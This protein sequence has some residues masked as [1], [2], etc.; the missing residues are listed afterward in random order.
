MDRRLCVLLMQALLWPALT[1]RADDFPNAAQL[2]G[3]QSALVLP[4]PATEAVAPEVPAQGVTASGKIP[5]GP[6][7]GTSPD[8]TTPEN[9]SASRNSLSPGSVFGAL[10]FV[11]LVILGLAKLVARKSPFAV[12]GLPREAIEVLGRR[13]IDPRNSV[14][15]VQVGSKILLLSSS[16]TGMTTLSEITDPIEVASLSNLCRAE[17]AKSSETANWLTGLF[18]GN[19]SA[20]ENRNFAERFGGRLSQDEPAASPPPPRSRSEG[21]RVA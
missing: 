5:I 15:V 20:P 16:A 13:T 8:S 1:V 3:D 19:E 11:V 9:G 2:R 21:R 10:V 6:R 18:R 12:S 14:Y 17:H 4:A 7:P